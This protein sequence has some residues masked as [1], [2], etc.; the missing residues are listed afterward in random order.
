MSLNI[1]AKLTISLRASFT[2]LSLSSVKQKMSLSG[3]SP[4]ISCFLFLPSVDW[5]LQNFAAFTKTDRHADCHNK[6]KGNKLVCLC[7][8]C[9]VHSPMN[10]FLRVSRRSFF[11]S[12]DFISEQAFSM[13]AF[14]VMALA[15]RSLHLKSK[16]F[17]SLEQNCSRIGIK[18]R[19][20]LSF[21]WLSKSRC[22]RMIGGLALCPVA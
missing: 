14:R 19:P 18:S 11:S 2:T 21:S 9:V 7:F 13:A 4:L 5:Y 16:C 6:Q 12:T 20:A 10:S 1:H 3:V 17:F 8:A 15:S 22:K